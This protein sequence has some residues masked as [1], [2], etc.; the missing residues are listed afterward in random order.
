[1]SKFGKYMTPSN[2][3][4]VSAAP[5]LSRRG[6]LIGAAG[7]GFTLAFFRP[8]LS[9]A[10]PAQVI[11]NQAFEP[12][13]WYQINRD[14]RIIVN[15]A[16]AEMGQHIGTALAR[17]V[18][19]EL[20]AD[21][22][23]VELNHV[24]SDPKWGV[25]VTG[26]SW[27]VWQNF[28][29]MSQAGAAGRIALIEEGAK[30]LGVAAEQ[31]QARNSRVI[32]GGKSVSYADIVSNGDITRSYS[33]E[34]LKQITLKPASQRRLIGRQAQAL[35][36]P[37]KTTGRSV[38]GLDARHADM[39]Y[40][41]PLIPPTRYGSSVNSIDDSAASAI[42]GY[43]KTIVL[44][45]PTDTVP[46]WALVIATSFHA[47]NR[48]A[49]LIKVDWTA[50]KTA[51]VS[52][53]DI[54]DHGRALLED[55]EK[56]AL[57]VNDP[58][59][60][61]AFANADSTL[62]QDY[63]THSVL[64]FQLE[65]VN[66]LAFQKDGIWEIHTGN[67]WQSLI[68]PVLAK[69]LEVPEEKIVMRTYMLGGGFGRRLNGDYALPAALAA[70]AL[71]RP[72]KVVFTR[73]DDVRFDS[74]RSPSF[75]RV[76][77]A[78]NA[79]GEV[80]GMQHHATAGWPTQVMA[81]F[82]MP[83]ATNGEPFDPFS[84]LGAAHWYAVGAHQLRAVS[85]DL[86]NDTFR[87]GWLRSVGSGWVNWALETFMDEAAHKAGKD[88]IEFRLGLLTGAGKNAGEAPNSVGG[89]SRQANVLRRVKALSGWGQ[90]LPEGTGLGVATTYGQERDMP[91][92]T[93]CVARVRVDKSTGQVT[94]EKLTLVTDAGTIVHPDG[95]RAQVEGAALWG[96][97]MA[98]H[99]GSLIENGQVRDTNLNSYTPLRMRD[100]PQLEI[101]F[102]DSTEAAV[103]LGEPATTVTGP[104][105]GNAI[106]NAVGVRM[107]EIPIRREAVL[108]A[109]QA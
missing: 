51:Q 84:I 20:E 29:P 77:M 100:V 19:D 42:D 69:A 94:L 103:G 91:T 32:A 79:A 6:F 60:E 13:L 1:M 11:E 63:V 14:G 12:T 87:P 33:E 66:A 30:L 108:A 89:A 45:D 97:S 74:L 104:A 101:E 62:Q 26:G 55:P 64:H 102:I 96:V 107:R 43:L 22:S 78:F 93:A 9:F 82:F 27:S 31:C 99:E 58:G 72:V 46:G 98:L 56:G 59:V 44:D 2:A 95:A 68:I 25:M 85:N 76:R 15:I 61:E 35:D 23:M 10:E 57:V 65:P 80:T 8:G 73:E 16:E 3:S 67:Q 47:A 53:Q 5:A 17:I 109:L 92:W 7:A 40:A 81:P 90:P 48:A 21:W 24:D 38:Y 52:E 36:I 105:I 88:P 50:G 39:V 37:E 54:L 49:A 70:K 86:A 71:G 106:F 18:A 41:R 34:Q 4:K 28:T 75:Q 83:D